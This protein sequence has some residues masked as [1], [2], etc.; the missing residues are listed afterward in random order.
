MNIS[1]FWDMMTFNVVLFADCLPTFMKNMLPLSSEST[2]KMEG[3]CFTETLVTIGLLGSTYQKTV[4]FFG[5]NIGRKLTL[6]WIQQ[7]K[8]VLL[9]P[10]KN[11]S[12]GAGT[13]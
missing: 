5:K 12:P 3:S 10:C 7:I 6:N 1:V 4:M 2:L 13:D 8:F 11:G 9:I